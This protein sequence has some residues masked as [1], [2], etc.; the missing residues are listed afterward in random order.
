MGALIFTR[1][2]SGANLMFHG[3]HQ[4]TIL[5]RFIFV[6]FPG[7]SIWL[8]LRQTKNFDESRTIHHNETG[9]KQYTEPLF[10]NNTQTDVPR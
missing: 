10:Q 3:N 5:S 1:L 8:Q 2:K 6:R 7:L 4:R 9:K